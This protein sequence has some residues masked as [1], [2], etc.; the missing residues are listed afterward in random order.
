MVVGN[1]AA[2]FAI[3]YA[4]GYGFPGAQG[5]RNGVIR[6]KQK[7]PGSLPAIFSFL[8]LCLYRG[9][10]VPG[11]GGGTFALLP[12]SSGVM[13]RMVTRRLMRLGPSVCSFGYCEP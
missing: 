3:N 9:G 12:E 13:R 1:E 10:T 6:A 4:R 11:G 7:W 2:V 5:R 8:K